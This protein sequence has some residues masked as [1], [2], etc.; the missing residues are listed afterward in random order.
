[1]ARGRKPSIQL[2]GSAG[3]LG[4]A[5]TSTRLA[6]AMSQKLPL[7]QEPKE[8]ETPEDLVSAEVEHL[9]RLPTS[10][11]LGR[12]AERL[13]RRLTPLEPGRQTAWCMS[14]RTLAIVSASTSPRLR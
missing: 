4:R 7:V 9:D 12:A 14:R 5:E 2:R 1:M 8:Q 3:I 10:R 6:A 13:L 11:I